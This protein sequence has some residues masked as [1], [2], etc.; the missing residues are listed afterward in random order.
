MFDPLIGKK[1]IGTAS[2]MTGKEAGTIW[3]LKIQVVTE[4][5]LRKTALAGWLNKLFGC[6][7]G[8]DDGESETGNLKLQ[9]KKLDVKYLLKQKDTHWSG[10]AAFW[11]AWRG[12]Y[13]HWK[14]LI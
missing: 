3:A 1:F 13:G 14:I 11:L 4:K 7:L 9:K 6:L 10:N 2:P 12:F 5:I 8:G